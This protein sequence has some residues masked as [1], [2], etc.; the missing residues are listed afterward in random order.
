V[1]FDDTLKPNQL[2]I[3]VGFK[4]SPYFQDPKEKE[5]R[6]TMHETRRL[7]PNSNPDKRVVEEMLPGLPPPVL[8]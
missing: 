6:K 5:I 4:P 1:G 2:K 3:R 7:T 8:P